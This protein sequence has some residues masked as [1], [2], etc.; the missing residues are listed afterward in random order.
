MDI[1]NF[2]GVYIEHRSWISKA[3][4]SRERSYIRSLCFVVVGVDVDVGFVDDNKEEEEGFVVGTRFGYRH[5]S[6]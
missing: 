3:R 2:W 1:Y 5:F 4:E 6:F